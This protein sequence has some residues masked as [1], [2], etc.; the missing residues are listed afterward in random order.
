M[1]ADC[2]ID[3][4]ATSGFTFAREP[5]VLVISLPSLGR[6]WLGSIYI[7]TYR[8]HVREIVPHIHEKNHTN[9]S[10]SYRNDS[11]VKDRSIMHAW[12]GT[13]FLIF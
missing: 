4:H 9:M 1:I 10:L 3:S 5:H 13:M 6:P 7:Y 12:H 2:N 11:V 8:M